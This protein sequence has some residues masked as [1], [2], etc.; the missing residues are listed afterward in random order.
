[1]IKK[2]ILIAAVAAVSL[3]AAA[4]ILVSNGNKVKSNG[5][6]VHTYGPPTFY[7][8]PQLLG[9]PIEGFPLIVSYGTLYKD[10]GLSYPGTI[11]GVQWRVA[12]DAN[13]TNAA[14]IAGAVGATY[15]IP[16]LTLRGKYI[17]VAATGNNTAGNSTKNAFWIGPVVPYNN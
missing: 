7:A 11:T 16:Y 14:N 9:T 8:Q 2:L 12:D 13:G 6:Q 17:G 15:R 4:A 1:M 3:N 5:A 10:S